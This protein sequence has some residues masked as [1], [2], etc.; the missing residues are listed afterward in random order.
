M[1]PDRYLQIIHEPSKARILCQTTTPGIV[2]FVSKSDLQTIFYII[3]FLL[4]KES[5]RQDT[6]AKNPG[7]PELVVVGESWV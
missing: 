6:P 4:K 5:T 7:I 3:P 1:P 2:K